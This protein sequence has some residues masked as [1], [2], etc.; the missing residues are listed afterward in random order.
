MKPLGNAQVIKH[1]ESWMLVFV[2]DIRHSPEKVWQAL[3]DPSELREWA[4]FDPDRN[5]GSSG[6]ALLAMAG[7]SS[8]PTPCVVRHADAPRLLE[9]T[10]GDDILRWELEPTPE[11]TRLTL[12]HTM[13]DRSWL[14]KVTAGW[15]ICLDV[16]DRF[17]TGDP[18]GRIVGDAARHHGWDELHDAYAARFTDPGGG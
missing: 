17:L 15:H 9:Y 10:W 3:T 18:I 7:E 14:P 1:G 12:R 11:G 4:P 2:R 16:L 13:A 8:E 5:L 6:E